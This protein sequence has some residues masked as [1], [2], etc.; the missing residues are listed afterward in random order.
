[1][2]LWRNLE[3][4][5]L[6]QI[7]LLLLLGLLLIIIAWPIIMAVLVMYILWQVLKIYKIHLHGEFKKGQRE[8]G[9]YEKRKDSGKISEISSP[10]FK[11]T[12][13]TKMEL[14]SK[15]IEQIR[16]VV[17]GSNVAYEW[18]NEQLKPRFRNFELI[19]EELRN[20]NFNPFLI[21]VDASLRHKIDSPEKLEEWIETQ[22]IKQAPSKIDADHLI[23]DIAQKNHA[24]ILSNDNFKDYLEKYPWIDEI[25]LP[26][27]IVKESVTIYSHWN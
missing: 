9:W 7:L 20:K 23:L 26:F 11:F 3:K 4:L 24:Y 14:D 25:R 21:I 8:V 19:T 13:D 10:E 17:D 5:E 12:G 16:T 1:M 6:W 22:I 18:R 2:G 27:S 15:N